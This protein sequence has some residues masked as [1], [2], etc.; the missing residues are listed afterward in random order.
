[1]IS[2]KSFNTCKTIYFSEVYGFSDNKI[3][4]FLVWDCD[5]CEN[6]L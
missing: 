4:D 2:D 5:K 1:M 6:E 3:N